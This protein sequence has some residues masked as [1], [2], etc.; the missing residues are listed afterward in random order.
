[1]YYLLNWNDECLDN[2]I[3]AAKETKEEIQDVLKKRIMDRLISLNIVRTEA[4]A[5]NLWFKAE[6]KDL[7]HDCDDDV[8][9]IYEMG[10]SISYGAGYTDHYHIVEFFA[11][12]LDAFKK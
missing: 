12:P 9:C 11:D 2:V 4:E 6:H 7:N 1:M 8:L 3:V 10:G 5:A